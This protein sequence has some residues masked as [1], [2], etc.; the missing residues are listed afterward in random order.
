LAVLQ[1]SRSHTLDEAESIRQPVTQ[2]YFA[3]VVPSFKYC[4]N[5]SFPT[6]DANDK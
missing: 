5:P 4:R 6:L 3:A 1:K 2:D